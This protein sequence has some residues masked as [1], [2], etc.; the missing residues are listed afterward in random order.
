MPNFAFEFSAK[1]WMK[2]VERT[3]REEIEGL[4]EAM[5]ILN[6]SNISWFTYPL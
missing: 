2:I 4:Q 3:E 6:A 1:Y 5:R